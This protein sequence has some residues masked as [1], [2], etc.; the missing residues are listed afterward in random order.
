[1]SE[2]FYVMG[3]SDAETRRLQLQAE[4]L[5]PITTRLLREAGI[6]PGQRVLEIGC[7]AGDVCL[8]AAELVG[9]SGSVL[10]LDRDPAVL[11]VAEQR[12]RAAGLDNVTTRHGIAAGFLDEQGFDAVIG[13]YV[14]VHQEDQP[15]FL[16]TA[17]RLARPGGVVAFHEMNALQGPQSLPR[18]ELWQQVA[19]WVVGV[20]RGFAPTSD[21]GG[22]FIQA[23]SAA[24]LPQPSVTCETPVGGGPGSLLY[25]LQAETLRSLLPQLLRAGG[26][27]EREVDVDTLAERLE[28]EVVAVDAQIQW[29]PQYCAW[30]RI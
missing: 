21:V 5:R 15:A 13:R 9:P 7:G 3:T 19:D 12:A 24:G 25:E 26:A 27:D 8:L 10:G 17:G 28:R 16:R 2:T 18:V 14:L 22:R 23:F 1:M 20:M 29:P 4:L 6:G 11:A 30:A